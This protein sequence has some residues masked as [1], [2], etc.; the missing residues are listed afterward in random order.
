MTDWSFQ[1]PGILSV[2]ELHV[3]RLNQ[4]KALA[5]AHV[6]TSDSSLEVFMLRAAAVGECLH[7]YGIHSFTLQPEL[8]RQSDN[9]EGHLIVSAEDQTA[10]L[11]TI[12]DSTCRV[13]CRT[14]CEDFTCCD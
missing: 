12:G 14:G 8:S 9:Q 3:W 5:T 10:R 7:A 11:R 2:H 6:V 13:R 1:L 4:Q